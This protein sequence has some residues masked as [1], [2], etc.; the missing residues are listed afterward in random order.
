MIFG[1]YS[2]LWFLGIDSILEG[3]FFLIT[4]MIAWYAYRIYKFGGGGQYRWWSGGF[5]LISLAFLTNGLT[6]YA[7]YSELMDHLGAPLARQILE[8]EQVYRVGFFLHAA[9]FLTGYLLLLIVSSRLSDNRLRAM[10][11]GFVLLIAIGAVNTEWLQELATG[12]LLAMI[13][14]STLEHT[15]QK[16]T[17]P[18]N[19]V[20]AGFGVVLISQLSFLLIPVWS[21]SYVVGHIIEFAGYGLLFTSMVFILRK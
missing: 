9:F 1:S 10:L 18:S 20:I 7:L 16:R 13:L 17:L 12:L 14:L 5:L 11:F 8:L 2:P 19:L 21:I 6:N 3:I 15:K 4:L